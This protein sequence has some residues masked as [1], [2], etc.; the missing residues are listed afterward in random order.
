M[1]ELGRHKRARTD[2]RKRSPPA[3]W[4]IPVNDYRNARSTRPESARS[5]LD[6]AVTV[7]RTCLFRDNSA[8]AYL[9]SKMTRVDRYLEAAESKNTSRSYASAIRHFEIEWK[10]LLPASAETVARYLADHAET[11]SA[12][13]LQHRLAALSRLHTGHG[14]PDPTK[15]PMVRQVLRG[16]RTVHPAQEKRAKPLQLDVLQQV[17]AW[18]QQ[19]AQAARAR[20]DRAAALRHARDRAL[21]LLGF[22]RGFRSDELVR[23]Q[24]EHVDVTHGEGLTCFIPRSKGDRNAEGRT[25]RCPALSRLCPVAAY[26][27][28]LAVSGLNDG[29][30]FRAIDRWGRIAPDGLAAASI[31]PLLRRLFGAVGLTEAQEYSS[32]SLRRGFA[33]WANA[34]GWDLK[35]LMEYVGWRDIKSALRYLEASPQKL[36]E[37][38]ERGLP[39]PMPSPVDLGK[40]VRLK[41][42]PS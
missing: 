4:E 22:W 21:V 27:A 18:L 25:F 31:I 34:N 39:E 28:W 15:A 1:A 42:V 35:E 9:T 29:P 13:T 40:P 3:G 37:R 2:A 26:E 32:H 12:N 11:L 38:F 30:V 16:I 36:R 19:A 10:G 7:E 41:T 33:G 20:G 6:R 5:R 23:L 8:V 24:I 14:F 17:D